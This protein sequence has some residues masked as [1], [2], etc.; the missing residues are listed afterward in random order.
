MRTN[1]YLIIILQLCCSIKPLKAQIF[2]GQVI[3]SKDAKPLYKAS[4]RINSKGVLTD[5]QGNFKLSITEFNNLNKHK[6]TISFVGYKTREIPISS[7]NQHMIVRLEENPKDLQEVIVSSSARGLVEEAI[8]KIPE[9]YTNHS[10]TLKGIL[11][12]S[13]KRKQG[14]ILYELKAILSGKIE[15]Y[16]SDKKEVDIKIEALERKSR[17]NLDTIKFVKWGGTAKV[18]QYFDIVQQRN[19]VINL[20]KTKKYKYFLEDIIKKNG[21][22]MYKIN[23]SKYKKKEELLGNIY[24]DQE[25]LAFEG[26]ELF[27]SNEDSVDLINPSNKKINSYSTSTRYKMINDKWYLSEIKISLEEIFKSYPTYLNVNFLAIEYDSSKVLNLNYQDKYQRVELLSNYEN[28]G[29]EKQWDELKSKIPAINKDYLKFDSLVIPIPQLI[30][31]IPQLTTP[32]KQRESNDK[33]YEYVQKKIK[34][35][36]NIGLSSQIMNYQLNTNIHSNLIPLPY[37]FMIPSENFNKR[38]NLPLFNFSV[39]IGNMK[40]LQVGFENQISFPYINNQT[41]NYNNLLLAYRYVF[42]R[43]HRPLSLQPSIHYG[44]LSIQNKLDQ[45]PSTTAQNE[46]LGLNDERLNIYVES[47]VKLLSLGFQFGIEINR[48]KYIDLKLSYTVPTSQPSENW[49]FSETKGFLIHSE[50]KISN[51]M[52]LLQYPINTFSLSLTYKF[53][54]YAK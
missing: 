4:I 30:S 23:V 39:N 17:F 34:I 41:S 32:I 29:N 6:V 35:N 11:T 25:N 18:F 27:N 50:K 37:G 42:N 3:D 31:P 20:K 40:G 45:L 21:R 36:L 5:N 1:L 7:F 2:T 16:S 19:T 15:S 43:K 49:I 24:I 44:N 13:N 33:F 47:K 22:P 38:S 14:E 28:K 51:S 46:L 12:E 26:F 9:N 8:R 48:T 53:L 54:P 10:Y 52:P